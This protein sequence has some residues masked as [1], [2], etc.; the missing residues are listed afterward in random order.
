MLRHR[1]CS[2]TLVLKPAMIEAWDIG[3]LN[4]GSAMK[5]RLH[6]TRQL[7][8]EISYFTPA[9]QSWSHLSSSNL[10]RGG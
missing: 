6:L 7:I 5:S 1:L 8:T 9:H 10:P 4:S 2:N 3:R